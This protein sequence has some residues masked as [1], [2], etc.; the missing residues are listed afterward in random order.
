MKN[1]LGLITFT[2]LVGV[3]MASL[4]YA[5]GEMPSGTKQFQE[6]NSDKTLQGEGLINEQSM[7]SQR[8]M[9]QAPGTIL[10]GDVL[11][12]DGEFY[13]VHDTAG[14]EVRVHID[15]TTKREGSLPFMTGDK[16]EI[17]MTNKGHALAI[18]HVDQNS[19]GMAALGPQAVR[20]DVLKIDG[21]FYTVHDTAGHEIRLHVDKTTKLEGG[22]PFMA[23]DKIEAQVTDKAHVLSLKHI[24]ATK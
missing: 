6:E 1:S 22:L 5:A 18:K 17:Q 16:V 21:E 8:Q 13:T 9:Q 11:K 20:G 23:G 7:K 12:I 14:H 4:T 3:V 2:A 10:K 15:K 19:G 24:A